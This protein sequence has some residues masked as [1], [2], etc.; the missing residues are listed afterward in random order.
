MQSTASRARPTD[1]ANGVTQMERNQAAIDLLRAW[2]Q[3]G[4]S[5]EQRDTGAYLLRV[6]QEDHIVIGQDPDGDPA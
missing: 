1:N 3:E 5:D 4:D 6:L 2:R